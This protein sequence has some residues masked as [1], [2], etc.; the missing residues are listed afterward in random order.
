MF[1]PVLLLRI[2]KQTVHKQTKI[3][4]NEN[5]DLYPLHSLHNTGKRRIKKFGQKLRTNL[6][7]Q[8]NLFTPPKKKTTTK[9]QQQQNNNPKTTTTKKA[10]QMHTYTCV[11]MCTHTY[12]HTC[13]HRLT[14]RDRHTAQTHKQV[15]HHL[16][17]KQKPVPAN[18]FSFQG[19]L[20]FGTSG[21]PSKYPHQTQ[22]L[23]VVKSSTCNISGKHIRIMLK[24][25]STH[26]HQT[27]S[28]LL[29]VIHISWI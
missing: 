14:H 17:W 15:F 18:S 23:L 10:T 13:T 1:L 4:K 27:K 29:W 12:T 9:K 3:T 24:H 8:A 19:S 21:I 26:T 20:S 5:V 6:V 11:Y 7:S 28:K 2:Q 25:P 22:S 16:S